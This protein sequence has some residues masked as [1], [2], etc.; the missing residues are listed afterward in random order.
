ME[1]SSSENPKG[2]RPS[3]LSIAV[4]RDIVS[5]ALVYA[6][7]VGALL[8]LINHG[9]ALLAG[10]ISIGRILKMVLTISVP[11]CVSTA[12]SVGTIRAGYD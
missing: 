5:R 10:D 6:L 11:Y 9:D 7:G 1:N 3:F 4:R 8:I 12:S 2:E